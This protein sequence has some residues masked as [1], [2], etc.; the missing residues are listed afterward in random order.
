MNIG[1]RG[2]WAAVPFVRTQLPTV[3]VLHYHLPCA[4]VALL[5]VAAVPEAVVVVRL[6]AVEAVEVVEAGNFMKLH[7]TQ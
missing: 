7:Q 3:L 1:L 2:M 4:A 6:A 5:R